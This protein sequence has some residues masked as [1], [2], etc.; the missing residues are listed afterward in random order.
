[1][2]TYSFDLGSR[3]ISKRS[4]LA[5]NTGMDNDLLTDTLYAVSGTAIVSVKGGA[6]GT[7]TWRGKRW[8]FNDY[9]GFGW[10]RIN[11]EL[12]AGAVIKLYGD[13]VLFYT[14]PLITSRRPQR[15]PPGKYRVW[16]L[17]VQSTDRLTSVVIAS[18]VGE[19][20]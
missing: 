1:V 20:Q 13:G 11:G 17:E 10:V 12:A 9:P 14:S 5:S 4:D 3:R 2:S 7:G 18:T 6:V 15:L 16:E 19:L 8:V